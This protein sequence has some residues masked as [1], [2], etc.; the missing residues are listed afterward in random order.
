[1]DLYNI[2]ESVVTN[3]YHI[4]AQKNEAS[5]DKLRYL[6]QIICIFLICFQHN[7]TYVKL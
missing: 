3:V 1:M 2:K 4:D 7:F 6:L 5:R